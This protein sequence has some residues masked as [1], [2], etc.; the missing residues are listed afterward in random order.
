MTELLGQPPSSATTIARGLTSTP[1]I[2]QDFDMLLKG[3]ELDQKDTGGEVTFTGADPI[4]RSKHRLGAIMA[5]GMMGPAVAT[6]IFYRMRGG[7]AQDLSVDLRKAVA[8]INPLF[9][10]KPITGGYPLQSPLLTPSYGAME[11]KIYPTK[12]DRWYLPTAIYPHM[13]V[14]WAGL[15]QSG[16]DVK[17][18]GQA[19]SQWNALD[20]E[21]AA[22]ERGMIGAMSRTPQ[23]WYAHPQG[24]LLAQTPMIEIIKIGDSD[25]DLPPLTNPQRPLSGINVASLTHVIAGPVTSRTLAEQGA[26]VLDLAN[27]SLEVGALVQDTHVGFRSTFMDLK[28]KPYVDKAVELI[29]DADVVIENYRSTKI[30]EFGLSAEEVAKIRPG[31]VYASVRGFGSDGPWADRGGFDMDA[32]V[33]TGYTA[34]E[35]SE[36]KPQLPPTV[37]LNDYLAGYLT[38]LGVL[39]ALIRRASHGGSYHV[40]TSLSRF[41][42]WYSELGVF[43]QSYMLDTIERPEHK[44]IPPTGFE[45]SGAFGKQVRLEP[46]ITYSRTP[47]YW[48]V[49]GE[50]TVVPLG[51]S[52]A[53]WLPPY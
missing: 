2:Y 10:F 32:N 14:D 29:R 35:G 43:D 33:A 51:A 40:R 7:P 41:S 28:Q 21:N 47:G 37:I 34:L 4:L 12:D 17:S 26:Q 38:A 31:I 36:D 45:L 53:T 24:A 48:E 44:P 19:I 1:D 18:V 20:L 42:M 23:E 25:P 16:L 9:L 27:P 6:Q 13:W 11:F 22:A 50:P 49:P 15:L 5:M 3:V 30:A 39:A 52:E 46:G 8:H